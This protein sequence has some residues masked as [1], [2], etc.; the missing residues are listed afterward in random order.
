MG[1]IIF[2]LIF[3]AVFALMNIYTYKRFISKLTFFG[4]IKSGFVKYL[5]ITLY[6][7]VGLYFSS[8]YYDIFNQKLLYLFSY[9]IGVMFML[10]TVA[11]IYDITHTTFSRV[12]LKYQKRKVLRVGVDT[13]FLLI[14][15]F[16]IVSGV[17]NGVKEPKIERVDIEGLNL[18]NFKIVQLSDVHIGN[19]IKRDFVE[20]MV[21]RVN[22]LN[23]DLIVLTGDL[24]D[25]DISKIERDVEPLKN[26]R[27]EYG[28]YFALGNHEYFHNPAK[29]L[30]H[31]RE[32]NIEVLENS[33]KVIAD[34]FNLVGVND[35]IGYRVGVLEPDIEK[36]INS[37]D[38]SLP[39]IVL[40]HQPKMVNEFI[41]RDIN[42][43]LMLSGHTHGGQIFP[44]GLLVLL[45]QPYLSGLYRVDEDSQIYVS[46]GTG[47]WGPAIRV[48]ADS[49]ITLLNI[50]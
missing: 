3:M 6:I 27:A 43:D 1:K 8:R 26:L 4:L 9:I 35:Y 16:Y 34:K 7:L 23:A 10:F 46:N 15:S 42:F 11:I 12:S 40:S 21:D 44:F 22:S 37:I 14:A 47:F 24:I 38:N 39:S 13:L 33:S 19:S 28:V 5:F 45:D 50:N 25:F 30:N 32:L 18:N 41:D 2:F 48:F 49:E 20:S 36:A 17:L 31:L 29:I